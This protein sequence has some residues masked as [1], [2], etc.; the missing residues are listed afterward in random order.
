MKKLLT[1]IL[2]L[3]ILTMI[4]CRD[5]NVEDL[6]VAKEKWSNLMA[7]KY[8]FEFRIDCECLGSGVTPARVIVENNKV[9]EVNNPTTGEPMINPFDSTL[10]INNLTGVF[11][12]VDELF[13]EIDR[14]QKDADVLKTDFDALNGFPTL[15]DIDW[16]SNADDDEVS[17]HVSNFEVL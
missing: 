8:G 16:I 15:I 5:V 3:A 6:D 12:T 4:A 7:E 9:T 2:F 1:G 10:V 13:E 14:A 17:Y 11:K